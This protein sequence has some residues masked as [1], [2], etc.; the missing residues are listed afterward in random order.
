MLVACE[1]RHWNPP[2]PTSKRALRKQC[3]FEMMYSAYVECDIYFVRDIYF[4]SD[5]CGRS[6][7]L[8][9][10]GS[11]NAALHIYDR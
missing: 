11:N 4:A 7:Y 2:S 1:A 9:E 8:F 6:P 3:S 5:M 10:V